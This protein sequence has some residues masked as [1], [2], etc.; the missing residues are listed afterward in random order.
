MSLDET[1]LHELILIIFKNAEMTTTEYDVYRIS[2]EIIDAIFDYIVDAE[3]EILEPGISS[4]SPPITDPNHIS[5]NAITGW[6][7]KTLSINPV[8]KD[9]VRIALEASLVTSFKDIGPD[10]LS[11]GSNSGAYGQPGLR[12]F[13]V[14]VN[15]ESIDEVATYH[16][17]IETIVETNRFKSDTEEKNDLIKIVKNEYKSGIFSFITSQIAWT[18]YYSTILSVTLPSD[19]TGYL[20]FKNI[21]NE[22]WDSVLNR[23]KPST[24]E[25][26]ARAISNPIHKFI[27]TTSVTANFTNIVY[28]QLKPE[29]A[30]I[31]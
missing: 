13:C 27:T 12:I 21:Y 6:K 23:G 26:G 19:L 18:G 16:N 24:I 28:T 20:L 22:M 17:A 4:S 9:E 1:K 7:T 29:T 2:K 31:K 11:L 25:E 8:L 15:E 10:I 30:T 3:I 14:G 5:I